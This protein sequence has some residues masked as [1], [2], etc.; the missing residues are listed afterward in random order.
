LTFAV[1]AHNG[2][3]AS[4][5][6]YQSGVVALPDS[7]W[8]TV[9]KLTCWGRGMNLT[10]RSAGRVGFY[11]TIC[12]GFTTRFLPPISPPEQ[13]LQGSYSFKGSPLAA[14]PSPKA[15]NAPVG[16]RA[17][18]TSGNAPVVRGSPAGAAARARSKQVMLPSSN[19]LYLRFWLGI[20]AIWSHVTAHVRGPA[21]FGLALPA[22]G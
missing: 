10:P 5:P 9:R 8:L 16:G 22:S 20:G 3:K 1:R 7:G 13:L 4:Y 6:L 12:S 11:L 2:F 14:T 19:R 21:R 17:A 18:I 15:K